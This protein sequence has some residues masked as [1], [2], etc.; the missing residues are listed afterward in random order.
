VRALREQATWWDVPRHDS[1]LVLASGGAQGVW[2]RRDPRAF[3]RLVAA[4]VGAHLR[5]ALRWGSVARAWRR[6]APHLAHPETW[7]VTFGAPERH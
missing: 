4:T 5:L 2:L 3:R 7:R 1:V 6:A